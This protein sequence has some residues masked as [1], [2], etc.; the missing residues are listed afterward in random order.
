MK[1]EYKIAMLLWSRLMVITLSCQRRCAIAT[2]SLWIRF[3]P[4]LTPLSIKRI[5]PSSI[6]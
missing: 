1:T 4:V 5:L 2:S 3:Q 6:N